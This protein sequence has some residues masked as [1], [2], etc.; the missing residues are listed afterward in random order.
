MKVLRV[1]I[2]PLK[3]CSRSGTASAA[4][5]AS[6]PCSHDPCGS[7]QLRKT[8]RSSPRICC[9]VCHRI[10]LALIPRDRPAVSSD[11][12]EPRVHDF[13]H[14]FVSA[15]SRLVSRERAAASR[16]FHLTQSRLGGR[17]LLVSLL[18]GADGAGS[19]PSG[20]ALLPNNEAQLQRLRLSIVT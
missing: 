6:C 8:E 18:S 14:R 7:R 17:D 1:G 2:L 11:H 10:F 3:A 19:R 5:R 9:P 20:P 12:S 16:A 15:V 13:R 4:N